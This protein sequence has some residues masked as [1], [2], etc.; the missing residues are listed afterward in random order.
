MRFRGLFLHSAVVG[1][2]SAVAAVEAPSGGMAAK[3]DSRG[4]M[5][6][7][8]HHEA[9]AGSASAAA[10]APTVHSERSATGQRQLARGYSFRYIRGA[11]G[12]NDCPGHSSEVQNEQGCQDA[13]VALGGA[14]FETGNWEGESYCPYGCTQKESNNVVYFNYGKGNGGAMAGY[15]FIC[16]SQPTECPSGYYKETGNAQPNWGSPLLGSERGSLIADKIEDCAAQCTPKADCLSFKWSPTY[17]WGSPSHLACIL[18]T[19]WLPTTQQPFKDFVYCSK[20]NE[21]IANHTT[22][23][24]QP[25]GGT[26]ATTEA[27]TTTAEDDTNQTNSSGSNDTEAEDVD[28]GDEGSEAIDT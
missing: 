11:W 14:G 28:D 27:P 16:D 17:E 9:V 20:T 26:V 2:V 4:R 3:L 15:A 19:Q 13:Y 22:T 12:H 10:A 23:P 25:P 18:Q 6:I 24:G 7:V 5:S 1:L 21:T 8:R